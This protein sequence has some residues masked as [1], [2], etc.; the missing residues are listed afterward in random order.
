[1]QFTALHDYQHSLQATWKTEQT[2]ERKYKPQS[3]LMPKFLCD[4]RL[5]K[6][7]IHAVLSAFQPNPTSSAAQGAPTPQDELHST[8]LIKLSQRS[9]LLQHHALD[10]LSS[11]FL[12]EPNTLQHLRAEGLWDLAFGNFFFF[13]RTA[14][15][16]GQAIHG[17]HCRWAGPV[18]EMCSLTA[19]GQYALP[20]LP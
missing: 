11:L 20:P 18:R 4:C 14:S 19:L 3:C 5:M 2:S 7:T 8:A 12:A 6:Q 10:F 16:E 17:K 9:C 1:M 15:T 13:W